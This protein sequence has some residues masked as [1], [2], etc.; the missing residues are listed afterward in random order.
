[1]AVCDLDVWLINARKTIIEGEAVSVVCVKHE[2][3]GKNKI[4]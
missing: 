3:R 1:M 4:N 2:M